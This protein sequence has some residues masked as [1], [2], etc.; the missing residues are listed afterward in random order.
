MAAED[1][2]PIDLVAFFGL[3]QDEA[4][5]LGLDKHGNEPNPPDEATAQRPLRFPKAAARHV[6]EDVPA[7]PTVPLALAPAMGGGHPVDAALPVADAEIGIAAAG[8]E[9]ERADREQTG[10]GGALLGAHQNLPEHAESLPWPT[11]EE[12][13]AAGPVL[14]PEFDVPPPPP[15]VRQWVSVPVTPIRDQMEEMPPPAW[16]TAGASSP[17]AFAEEVPPPLVALADPRDVLAQDIEAPSTGRGP[18]GLTDEQ[19]AELGPDVLRDLDRAMTEQMGTMPLRMTPEG[20]AR[21]VPLPA[22]EFTDQ[23]PPMPGEGREPVAFSGGPE[24]S[25]LAAEVAVPP[26]P[27]P[28]PPAAPE[29]TAAPAPPGPPSQSFAGLAGQLL[30]VFMDEA[31]E[32][33]DSLHA[34]LE[35]LEH[36]RSAG[37]VIEA[38]R[39]VHT[40]KGG[41]R[42]CGLKAITNLAHACEDAIGQ[43]M[44]GQDTLPADLIAIL[45]EAEHEMRAALPR[46]ADGPGSDRSLD[47]MVQRLRRVATQDAPSAAKQRSDAPARM[48]PAPRPSGPPSATL[49]ADA[50]RTQAAAPATPPPDDLFVASQPPS[51]RLHDRPALLRRP[52]ITSVSAQGSRLAVD[53]TKVE[54]MVAKVTEIVANRAASHGLVK[55]LSG[56]VSEVMRTVHRL[57]SITVALQYQIASYGLD[58]TP[59]QDPDGL[60]LE[61]YGPVR[62]LMLQLAEAVSD[63]Q[64]LVQATMDVVTN[65][66]AL[67]A[68]EDRLD[69]DLQGALLN[70]RLLPLSQLRVRLDQVVRSAAATAGR[71]VR[72]AMEG[73]HV[74]LD[75]H[76]CDRLFEPLMHLM[77]NAID[78]GIEPPKER[79]AKGKPHT[80]RIV[81]QAVVEGNQAMVSVSDDGR[82]MDPDRIAAVAVER[83][84]ISAEQARRLG[85]R[86]KLELIFRP[87]FSTAHAVTEL[88]GRGMGM[89]IVREACSRMGGSVSIVPR[90]GGGTTVTLQVPLS[91]SVIHAVI[92]RDAGRLLA[93]PAS[94]VLSVHLVRPGAIADRENGQVVRIGH[95]EARLY[96]FP[97]AQTRTGKGRDGDE[98]SVLIVP[99]RGERVALAVDEMVNEDDLIVKPL[100]LLLQGVER[101]LGAV[102]L[103]D[104]VPAPVLNLPPLLDA[105]LSIGAEPPTAAAEAAPPEE[106]ILVV[107]DSL[108]M[109][110]AL[111]QSLEH[112]G[113]TVLT[114][115]DGQEAL[116]MIRING[117]PSLV[118]LDIEMPRM[119]GLETLFAIR[120]MPGGDDLPI[121]MLTSRGSQQHMRTALKMGASRYFTKPYRD[122]EFI[123]AV[124]AAISEQGDSPLG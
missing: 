19:I 28:A 113:Y 73:Q 32:M 4:Q 116:E 64:A 75:K 109:R 65:K 20:M 5:S 29:D 124:Q 107:D 35:L 115:R 81:V 54:G 87:G 34:S 78:H 22:S 102:I 66:R 15:G 68:I 40:I 63:Q 6:S 103:P 1:R 2:E 33:L 72:W 37:A 26:S 47:A 41:A 38:R 119:D 67:A 45:F 80:G 55:T 61:T 99:H 79:E 120:Q 71:E 101:L 39:T 106:V 53:L 108:T 24:L 104:G 59:E 46:P 91:M 12:M 36:G 49:A 93:I 89:E 76:V 83:G 9:A 31:V 21:E 23:I 94:Q 74:A 16:S 60:A 69:T 52:A 123:G 100:P 97:T 11:E 25:A 92:I 51:A 8:G 95:E 122:S 98:L 14:D 84:V 56:T 27:M 110:V 10:P 50:A 3:S 58:I 7:P 96:R 48:P 18:Y 90:P 13:L 117:L 17:A 57:Q 43:P 118:T 42:M 77:R 44:P 30:D 82:G 86:D 62:Q 105:L 70:M 111:S 114:A 112:A 121:F 85:P 88:S